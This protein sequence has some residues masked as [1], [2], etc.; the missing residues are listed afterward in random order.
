MGFR[1]TIGTQKNTFI[2]FK[3]DCINCSIRHCAHV[4]PKTFFG[5]VYMMKMKSS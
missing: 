2:H 3:Q 1:V 4:Q 5:R